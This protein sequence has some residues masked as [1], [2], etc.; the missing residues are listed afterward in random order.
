MAYFCCFFEKDLILKAFYIG[1]SYWIYLQV[2]ALCSFKRFLVS[3]WTKLEA[4]TKQTNNKTTTQAKP[5]KE[6][7]KENSGLIKQSSQPHLKTQLWLHSRTC[8]STCWSALLGIGCAK[9]KYVWQG[10]GEAHPGWAPRILQGGDGTMPRFPTSAPE[11]YHKCHW[12]CKS[13]YCCGVFF[14]HLDRRNPS[15]PYQKALFYDLY[16][17]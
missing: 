8:F 6:T 7:Y 15:K 4:L 2:G 14:L 16:F 9:A 5:N 1:C 17:K 10:F 12:I 13:T 3:K 11:W